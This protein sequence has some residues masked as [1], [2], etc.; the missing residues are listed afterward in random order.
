MKKTKLISAGVFI[1]GVA[2]SQAA[3][4]SWGPVGSGI[5]V[6]DLITDGSP[7]AAV[8]GGADTAGGAVTIGDNVFTVGPINTAVTGSVSNTNN[9]GFYSPSSGDANLDIIMDSHTYISAANPNGVGQI[10]IPVTPGNSYLVQF[11][12]V[13]DDRGCCLGRTQFVEDGNGNISGALTRGDGDWVVGTFTADDV[14][15]SF[16]VSGANDPGLSGLIVRDLGAVPEPG[17]ALLSFAGLLGLALRR[18]R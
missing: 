6:G 16:F 9:G 15:Q 12:G 11:I 2:L 5:Q 18:R 8:N 13:G 3:T 7:Y 1:G 17:T 10:D 4:V 14:N